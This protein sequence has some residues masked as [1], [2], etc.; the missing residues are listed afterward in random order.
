MHRFSTL[1]KVESS[2]Y[3]HLLLLGDFNFPQIDWQLT[4]SSHELENQFCNLL[5]DFSLI[6][7][8]EDPTHIHG[9]ILDLV[10]TYFPER[11]TK[12]VCS[13]SVVNSDHPEVYFE[14]NIKGTRKH[15]F[16]RV[17]YKYNKDDFDNLRTDL[18]NANLEQVLDMDDICSCWASLLSIIF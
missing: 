10:A 16:S 17:C 12:P 13:N 4:S 15:N 7:L 1:T 9:N 8:I 11:L 5:D 18:S 3:S 2:R 6:Q 14:I